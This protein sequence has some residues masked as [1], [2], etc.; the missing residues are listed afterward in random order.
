MSEEIVEF[1]CEGYRLFGVSHTPRIPSPLGLVIIG[2]TCSDRQSVYL[3]RAA[4]DAGISTFRFD[5][6]GRGICEGPPVTVE[7]TGADLACA[8]N[9]AAS[10]GPRPNEFCVWGLSE[11][12]ATALLYAHTDARVTSLILVNP[13]IRME[14]AVA[15]QH[16]KENLTR[17]R[18]KDFWQR[19][20]R[21]EAGYRGAARSFVRLVTNVWSASGKP[22][23]L[24]ERVIDGLSRFSGSI[25]IIL[26][27]ADPATAIFQEVAK[28][29]LEK[30]K[31]EGRLTLHTLPDA[32]HVFSRNDWRQQLIAWSVD[33]VHASNPFTSD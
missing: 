23:T 12:A 20:R 6:R 14:R 10:T 31:R 4:S 27:L 13:W 17:V 5:F 29:I 18:R 11:G 24:K 1:L 25:T 26:S 19:I 7:E 15:E 22:D 9:A 2:K 32:D 33:A 28:P 21:S 30:L 3:A 8:L 16:L